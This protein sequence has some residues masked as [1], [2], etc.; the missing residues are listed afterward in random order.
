MPI[1]GDYSQLAMASIFVFYDD[2]E[3]SSKEQVKNIIR[4]ATLTSLKSYKK[5][6]SKEFGELILCCDSGDVWRKEVFKYYKY[7]RKKDKAES[8]IDWGFVYECMNQL[9]QDLIDYFPYKVIA[10]NRAE[11]D[12][13]IGVLARWITENEQGDG[14][15]A[16]P[17]KILV[18]SSDG[19][20]AQL[21]D[22]PDL[23]QYAP[24]AKKWIEKSK[25]PVKALRAHIA[26]AGDDG[27]PSVLSPDNVFFEGIRQ[28][29][30]R[31]NRLEEFMEQGVDACRNEDEVAHWKRNEQLISFEHI[32]EDI[33]KSIIDAY[34][35]CKPN[36]D[37]MKM[38]TYLMN[39]DC[40]MLIQD[41]QDF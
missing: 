19:D 27:I 35:N 15:Y 37:K 16:D 41:I 3:K 4:H 23:K 34:L 33:K 21:H 10:V 14:L 24:A 13:V 30:L 20:Y 12:D 31:Q 8:K 26:K 6:Y 9:Q 18:A 25:D 5:T 39:N 17:P 7:K 1:L 28:K 32:P 22:I 2:L 38:M 36:K 29:P 40:Q 11:G